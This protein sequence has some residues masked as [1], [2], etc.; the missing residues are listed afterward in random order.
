MGNEL[1]EIT[2]NFNENFDSFGECSYHFLE[3]LV[4]KTPID[5][6]QRLLKNENNNFKI[7]INIK[8]NEKLNDDFQ[9]QDEKQITINTTINK[10]R[11]LS[12]VINEEYINNPSINQY[13]FNIENEKFKFS[14]FIQ[15]LQKIIEFNNETEITEENQ[16]VYH[17]I[18]RILD[19]E[20]EKTENNSNIIECEF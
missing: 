13:I 10:A 3:M 7:I 19:N 9:I 2:K 14:D 6:L 11:V 20:K 18:L 12:K 4:Y 1:F 15:I 5:N 8:E 17:Q 16:N